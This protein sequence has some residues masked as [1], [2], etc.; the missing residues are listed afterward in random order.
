MISAGCAYLFWLMGEDDYAHKGDPS[1]Y[2]EWMGYHCCAWFSLL[3]LGFL[4][5]ALGLWDTI[6]EWEL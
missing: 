5:Y 4:I 6:M 1:M 3:A 2:P